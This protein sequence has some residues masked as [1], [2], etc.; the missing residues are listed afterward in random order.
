MS[1]VNDRD[2]FNYRLGHGVGSWPVGTPRGPCAFRDVGPRNTTI[3]AAGRGASAHVT[4]NIMSMGPDNGGGSGAT[5]N[6]NALNGQGKRTWHEERRR[7]SRS[8]RRGKRHAKRAHAAELGNMKEISIKE[9]EQVKDGQA[10]LDDGYQYEYV[11]TK[12]K[13]EEE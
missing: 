4:R 13:R 5:A 3:P 12:V 6:Q 10:R 1:R 11:M 9:E 2:M 7:V 8:N